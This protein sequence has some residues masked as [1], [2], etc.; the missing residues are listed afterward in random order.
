MLKRLRQIGFLC[1]WYKM[2][3]I[4]RPNQ[5]VVNLASR[6]GAYE[7]L[8]RYKYA[9]KSGHEDHTQTQLSR[10]VIWTCWLQGEDAAPAIVR[11]CIDSIRQYANGYE[12]VVIDLKNV[13]Q[14]IEL[15]KYIQEKYA[16]GIIPHAHYSDLIRLALLLKYGGVWIDSTILLTDILPEYITS[17]DFFVFRGYKVGHTCIYNPFLAAKQNNPILQSLL[18][19]LSEYW[20]NEN[21]LVSYSIFH[22]FFT[23][24]I[25]ASDENKLIWEKVPLSYGSQMFYLQSRLGQ[26]YDEQVFR[27]ATQ[28]SSIHKLT[29]KPSLCGGD[30]FQ[31]GTFYDVLI[32]EA[33]NRTL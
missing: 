28:L 22:L 4:L 33:T 6:N 30:P 17:A 20:K 16:K 19:L 3:N 26:P 32:N 24:A 10:R 9:I 8:L 23:I 12:V 5:D 14:Y 11:R 7:Y 13:S 25:E 31:K 27:L 1:A 2:K 18:N 29:Y 15:P 21:K